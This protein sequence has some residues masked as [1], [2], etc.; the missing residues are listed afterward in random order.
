MDT[1]SLQNLEVDPCSLEGVASAYR[2]KLNLKNEAL[3]GAV[4]N[5]T[6]SLDVFSFTAVD[7]KR[8]LKK[9]EWPG[10][11]S[12]DAQNRYDVK[13]QLLAGNSEIVN[14][15]GCASW[16]DRTR[17]PFLVLTPTGERCL[18]YQKN[19]FVLL[20]FRCCPK[21]HSCSKQFRLVISL[22]SPLT[23]ETLYSE[24][25]IYRKKMVSTKKRKTSS[26]PVKLLD[27]LPSPP[28]PLHKN[29]PVLARDALES[30]ALPTFAYAKPMP[31]VVSPQFMYEMLYSDK[32]SKGFSETMPSKKVN[33]NYAIV[34][35]T[36]LHIE[37]PQP[38]LNQ[39]KLE[40]QNGPKKSPVNSFWNFDSHPNHFHNLFHDT[41]DEQW[42]D[43][44]FDDLNGG[45]YSLPRTLDDISALLDLPMDQQNHFS[46]EF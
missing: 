11:G 19:P 44:V 5:F 3:V 25:N 45:N 34:E 32:D 33:R 30:L 6:E 12:L 8:A 31:H 20:I 37:P 39:I 1:I 2:Y 13:I 7:K 40:P 28:L 21:F 14:C 18:Q 35:P 17:K 22:N 4:L 15:D 41:G 42:L 9:E 26:E 38:V 27:P 23:G 16:K 10:V 46:S 24:V 36:P 43:S 29:P